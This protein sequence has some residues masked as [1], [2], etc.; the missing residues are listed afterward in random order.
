MRR[1]G[2]E[3]VRAVE[4]SMTELKEQHARELREKEAHIEHLG[5]V[6]ADLKHKQ[7]T[8]FD[9]DEL[10]IEE[11]LKEMNNAY[12]GDQRHRLEEQLEL[13]MTE[14]DTQAGIDSIST[15]RAFDRTEIPKLTDRL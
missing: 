3:A 5:L 9:D 15:T 13:T 7:S 2:I 4:L 8:L 11:K 10:G 6:V 14:L 1:T 12:Q